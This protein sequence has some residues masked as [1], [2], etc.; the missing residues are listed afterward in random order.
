MNNR[1][2]NGLGA[3]IRRV[4][5]EGVGVINQLL[6]RRPLSNR[7]YNG[8]SD[9]DIIDMPQPPAIY[10]EK[11]WTKV[12]GILMAVAGFCSGGAMLLWSTMLFA[13]SALIGELGIGLALSSVNLLLTAGC[14]AVGFKGLSMVKRA[15]RF[16]RYVQTIGGEEL[17]NI[18]LLADHTGKSQKYVV[19]DVE[20]MIQSGWFCQGHLDDKKTCLML[21]DNMYR[22]YQKLER[23]KAQIQ[24]EEEERAR[25]QRM[26]EERMREEMEK[27]ERLKR[28]RRGPIW[29]TGSS[30]GNSSEQGASGAGEAVWMSGKR[31]DVKDLYGKK[32]SE[33]DEKWNHLPEDVQKVMEQGEAYIE[34]IRICN[35]RIPGEEISAKM[36]RMELLLGKIFGRVEQKP[37][38]VGDI[39][40]LMEYY[41]PTT[42]KLLETYADMDGQPFGGENIQTTKKEIEDSL[43]T[44][45]AAY[46]K[47]LDGMYQ[48]TAWDVSSDIS[49]LKT[50]LAQEGLGSDGL[51][52]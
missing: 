34:K 45:N 12:V 32:V 7:S 39:R 31:R 48:D 14:G 27:E 33:K 51:K 38:T 22:E 50:M 37:E 16:E 18:K 24:R 29:N 26:E 42:I 4:V 19:K 40:R 25:K 23:E 9:P 3:L 41:L 44:I 20:K 17:C 30:D 10:A 8:Y 1:R 6:N 35:D 28:T 13:G 11:P 36:E 21:T 5:Q 43:D 15:N 49:V 2:G 46:E 52:R 47:L